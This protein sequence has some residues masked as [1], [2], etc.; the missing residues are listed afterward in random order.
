LAS[1]R[2]TSSAPAA[3]TYLD[4]DEVPA[5][6]RAG[7]WSRAADLYFPG[8]AARVPVTARQGQLRGIRCGAGMLWQIDSPPLQLAWSPRHRLDGEQRFSVLVQLGGT[9]TARQHDRSCSIRRDDICFLDQNTPFELEVSQGS[10]QLMVLQLPRATV[11]GRN[12]WLEHRT[13]ETLDPSDPGALLLRGMLLNLLTLAPSLN[14]HQQVS[15]LTAIQHLLA[16]P[17]LTPGPRFPDS[18]WR[19]REALAYIDAS[20]EDPSLSAE[21]VARQQG[22][23]RR[24]LDALMGA[25][26][27]LSVTARIWMRRLERACTDLVDPR[28]ATRTVTDIA[29]GAGFADAAHFTK[30]FKQRYGC[31]PSEWRSRY[32]AVPALS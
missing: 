30:A 20:L 12:P 29:F 31:T 23:S 1:L 16:A 7:T 11:L 17:T 18:E 4:L 5:A 13:A 2:T 8:L 32:R 22:V 19:I 10:S 24:R 21:A 3:P 15:A 28:Q 26:I 14:H 25:R 6:K 27:G 9:T